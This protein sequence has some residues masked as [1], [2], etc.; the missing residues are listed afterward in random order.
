[1]NFK[2][3]DQMTSLLSLLLIGI[4]SSCNQPSDTIRPKPTKTIIK[5]DM[6]DGSTKDIKKAWFELIH[7]AP[8]GVNWREIEHQNE[9]TRLKTVNRNHKSGEEI[10]VDGFLSGEWKERGSNNQ[11]GSVHAPQY[12]KY[13]DKLYVISDG[14]I[15]W[16]SNEHGEAWTPQNHFIRLDQKFLAGFHTENGSGYSIYSNLHLS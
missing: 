16:K 1:M 12:N 2:K 11:A 5:M 6:E 7:K 15:L 14:G 3:L 8:D 4:L 9:L 10:I 13:T